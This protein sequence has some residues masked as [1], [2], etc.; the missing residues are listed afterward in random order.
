MK[1][2]VTA[3]NELRE[4]DKLIAECTKNGRHDEATAYK[5]DKNNLA[6]AMREEK[7]RTR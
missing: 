4:L 3:S 6:R 5:H 2:F 1:D 7:E